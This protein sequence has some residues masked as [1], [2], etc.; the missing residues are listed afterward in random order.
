MSEP[1]VGDFALAQST[2]F[3]GRL[4]YLLDRYAKAIET[5]QGSQTVASR[6]LAGRVG[7][8]PGGMAGKIAVSLV[9]DGGVTGTSN[10]ASPADSTL[11][12]A[13][14]DGIIQAIWNSGA[15]NDVL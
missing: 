14:L 8:D 1:S 4:Q 11:T 5:G 10:G 6:E 13:Q 15:W 9:S 7:S 3:T 2:L 12:D